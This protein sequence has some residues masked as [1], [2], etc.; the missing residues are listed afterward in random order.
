M[1][2][3]MDKFNFSF[4]GGELRSNGRSPNKYVIQQPSYSGKR[5]F[6]IPRGRAYFL[7]ALA[8]ASLVAAFLLAWFLSPGT[9]FTYTSIY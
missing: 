6:L 5:P 7:I 3:K 4:S 8:M 2:F 1:L 9:Y